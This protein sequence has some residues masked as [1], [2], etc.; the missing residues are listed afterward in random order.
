M[1]QFF[2]ERRLLA[3][4][5]ELPIENVKRNEVVSENGSQEEIKIEYALNYV[6]ISGVS[7]IIIGL[8]PFNFIIK[9]ID[10]KH[11]YGSSYNDSD[12]AHCI[13]DMVFFLRSHG[14]GGAQSY[15]LEFE[16][17]KDRYVEFNDNTIIIFYMNSHLLKDF[18]EQ[19]RKLIFP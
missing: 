9:I 12:E 19:V 3:Y 6:K 2:E 11:K 16:N 14:L 8:L 5:G 7:S 10:I 18:F 13:R 17:S 4:S 1:S 15:R